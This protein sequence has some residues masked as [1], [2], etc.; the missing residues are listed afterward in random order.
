MSIDFLDK[1]AVGC[2]MSIE[3]PVDINS[4]PSFKFASVCLNITLIGFN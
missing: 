4:L 3:Q 1:D 2:M